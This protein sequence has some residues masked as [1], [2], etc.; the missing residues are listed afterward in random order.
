[1]E[2]FSC[3]GKVLFSTA[4]LKKFFWK[5]N[6]KLFLRAKTIENLSQNKRILYHE[7]GRVAYHSGTPRH[8]FFVKD[9]LGNVRKVIRGPE[10]DVF[11][12]ATLG[13]NCKV[14]PAPLGVL[15]C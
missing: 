6:I 1:M 9:H 4:R 15:W 11:R 8:E 3:Q 14:H 10:G 2:T 13:W 7:E 12:I 5:K